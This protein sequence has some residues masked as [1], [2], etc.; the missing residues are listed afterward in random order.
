M[1]LALLRSVRQIPYLLKAC[2][3]LMGD[4]VGEKKPQTSILL[5]KNNQF[6]GKSGGANGAAVEPSLGDCRCL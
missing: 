5:F 1:T 6:E 4:E 2:Q 3:P